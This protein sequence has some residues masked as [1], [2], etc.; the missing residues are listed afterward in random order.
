MPGLG[1]GVTGLRGPSGTQLGL[2][3]CDEDEEVV[4]VADSP[5]LGEAMFALL[6]WMTA[7]AEDIAAQP[8]EKG[9]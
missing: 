2:P 6:E 3:G 1:V 7:L 5:N 9:S 4:V 8:G